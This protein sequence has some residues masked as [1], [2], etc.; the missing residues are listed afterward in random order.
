MARILQDKKAISDA[1]ALEDAAQKLSEAA[2]ELQKLEFPQYLY[3]PKDI[4]IGTTRGRTATKLNTVHPRNPSFLDPGKGPH[5]VKAASNTEPGLTLDISYLKRVSDVSNPLPSSSPFISEIPRVPL[6]RPRPGTT[7]RKTGAVSSHF[8]PSSSLGLLAQPSPAKPKPKP[9]PKLSPHFPGSTTIPPVALDHFSQ[10]SLPSNLPFTLQP[11]PFGL[12]QERIADSLYALVVQAILWNKTKGTMARPILFTLLSTYP[13]PD[14]LAQ[15][16]EEEVE[17][18]IRTLGLQ[19][20]RAKT[21]IN[22]G[23]AWVERPPTSGRRYGR[24]NYPSY[25][26]PHASSSFSLTKC[27]PLRDGELLEE[28]D[29]REGWE[30]AHLPGIGEYA[31]DSY[32]I[33]GRDR[34]R[35]VEGMEGVEPEWKRVTPRDKEL[36]PYVRFKWAQEGWEY[37][38]AT[39]TRRRMSIY[40]SDAQVGGEAEVAEEE[41]DEQR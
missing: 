34:L 25:P 32:R 39:G 19:K 9:T 3:F 13:T 6:G 38:I 1:W 17:A 22:V 7:K 33:F 24:R 37:D 15:A 12:I 41:A 29:E 26:H 4:V 11:A 20:R 28:G 16:N 23:K 30:I 35:A 8:A 18:I 27:K 5:I 40:G 10:Y 14:T 31:L 36:A 2:Q 21:L